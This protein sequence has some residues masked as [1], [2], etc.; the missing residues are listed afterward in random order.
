VLRVSGTL[1]VQGQPRVVEAPLARRALW[2]RETPRVRGKL[3]AEAVWRVQWQKPWVRGVLQ[4]GKGGQQRELQVRGL[5]RALQDDW[6]STDLGKAYY[7]GR[8]GSA[9]VAPLEAGRECNTWKR[10]CR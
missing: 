3:Q 2:V 10:T 9:V 6:D 5:Q 1:W 4:A 7:V 8:A